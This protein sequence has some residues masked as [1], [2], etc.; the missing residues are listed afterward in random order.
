VRRAKDEVLDNVC[1]WN[2]GFQTD[3]FIVLGMTCEICMRID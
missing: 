2:L 3:R 1:D